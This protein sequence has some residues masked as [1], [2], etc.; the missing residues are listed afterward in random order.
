[1]SAFDP[2]P[3][4]GVPFHLRA[5]TLEEIAT[6]RRLIASMERLRSDVAA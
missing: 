3:L 6:H 5:S 4:R 1:M 2:V